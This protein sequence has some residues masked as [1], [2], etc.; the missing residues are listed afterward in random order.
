MPESEK[1]SS[2]RRRFCAPIS[3]A[4]SA[5]FRSAISL[6][7]KR[8][9]SPKWHDLP[10]VRRSEHFPHPLDVRGHHRQPG[11]HR[12]QHDI[13]HPF[14]GRGQHQQ[15]AVRPGSPRYPAANR[16]NARGRRS[17]TCRHWASSCLRCGPFPTKS[18]SHCG[19][20]GS[21]TA[22]DSSSQTSP[23][24]RS[25]RPTKVT[26][27]RPGGRIRDRRGG[28]SGP[29][30]ASPAGNLARSTPL[31]ITTSFSAGNRASPGRKLGHGL[32]DADVPID[33]AD[34]SSDPA[35]VAS[36]A[37]A[38]PRECRKRPSA[39]PPG[40]RRSGRRYW[41]G[42]ERSVP[43]AD[44]GPKQLFQA[45][46]DDGELPVPA[47]AQAMDL[48]AGGL[49]GLQARILAPRRV[50][51]PGNRPP[52]ENGRGPVGWPVP[53]GTVRRPQRQGR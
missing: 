31:G 23:F 48:D 44:F 4:I 27:S 51:P 12:L 50:P 53:P 41:H 38:G 8:A 33:Q 36:G 39:P 30:A 40:V 20:R 47:A 17:P 45:M 21:Q 16:Q 26:A 9:V 37:A 7:A 49:Q 29:C 13:G 14:P 24:C 1:C 22:A 28:C 15:P 5:S 43:T 3:A 25:N 32:A 34:R 10:A 52:D 19:N 18:R 46:H 35:R 6:S 11:G 42:K 2:T